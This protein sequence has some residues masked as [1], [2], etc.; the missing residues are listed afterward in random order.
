VG[1]RRLPRPEV[2]VS[3]TSI[4]CPKCDDPACGTGGRQQLELCAKEPEK[5]D[6]NSL[7][8]PGGFCG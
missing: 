2:L 6:F 5:G 4:L 1:T 7:M 3:I 8:Y